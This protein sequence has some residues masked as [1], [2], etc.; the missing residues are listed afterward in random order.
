MRPPL[1]IEL[2]PRLLSGLLRANLERACQDRAMVKRFGREARDRRPERS[3]GKRRPCRHPIVADISAVMPTGGDHAVSAGCRSERFRTLESDFR[4][5]SN[6][7]ANIGLAEQ[8]ATAVAVAAGRPPLG[9]SRKSIAIP[10]AGRLVEDFTEPGVLVGAYYHLFPHVLGG[11]L[12]FV[13]CLV[14]ALFSVSLRVRQVILP[15][16]QTVVQR[17]KSSLVLWIVLVAHPVIVGGCCG[18][19]SFVCNTSRFVSRSPCLAMIHYRCQHVTGCLILVAF[20]CRK[21]SS[22]S[23]FISKYRPSVVG[24]RS[25]G[26]LMF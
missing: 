26:S 13:E 16:S 9:G 18:N 8:A 14:F 10:H 15:S 12:F 5:S 2:R 1:T 4:A 23:Y 19:V 25:P 22:S 21:P 24:P 17:V 20:A 6:T 3:T 11:P 7:P